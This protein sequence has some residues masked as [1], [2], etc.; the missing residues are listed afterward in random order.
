M[1]SRDIMRKAMAKTQVASKIPKPKPKL[2]NKM[3]SEVSHPIFNFQETK[4]KDLNSSKS[5][6]G[7]SK[8]CFSATK[9]NLRE[10]RAGV[11]INKLVVNVDKNDS[12]IKRDEIEKNSQTITKRR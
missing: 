10:E 6:N 9:E 4:V 12:R 7:T 1:G 2:I 3:K 11:R 5:L 8:K